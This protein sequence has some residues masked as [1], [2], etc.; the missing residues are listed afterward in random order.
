[1]LTEC[2]FGDQVKW[3]DRCERHVARRGRNIYRIVA[4]NVDG[5]RP[6][7]NLSVEIKVILK[8]ILK[9]EGVR[10]WTGLIWLRIETT[11]HVF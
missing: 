8:R 7:V 4:R 1:M 3:D 11:C 5:Q 6:L 2:Y 10:A 9:Q